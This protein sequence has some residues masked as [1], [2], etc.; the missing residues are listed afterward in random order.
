MVDELLLR[1]L[2]TGLFVLSGANYVVA[3]IGQRGRW[4]Y[5]VSN[6]L[7]LVMA[8]AMVVMIWPWGIH[9]PTTG[10]AA[11]FLLAAG[12]FIALTVV[13]AKTIAQWTAGSYHALMMLAM[14]WMYVVMNGHLLPGNPVTPHPASTAVSMPG[15]EMSAMPM[16]PESSQPGWVASVNWLW[17]LVFTIAAIVWTAVSLAGWRRGATERK[18][19]ILAQTGRI[20]MA[21]AM[22]IVFAALLSGG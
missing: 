17:F 20:S 16:P 11:F 18:R 12:W 2:V 8:I 22:A 21:L 4:V 14:T 9:A 19:D 5:L 6:G 1:W 7:H 15:M 10:P 13:S 3:A